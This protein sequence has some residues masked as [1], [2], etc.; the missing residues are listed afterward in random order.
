MFDDLLLALE[1]SLCATC[2]ASAFSV[3]SR[4]SVLWLSS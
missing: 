4:S 1:P 3:V 2:S